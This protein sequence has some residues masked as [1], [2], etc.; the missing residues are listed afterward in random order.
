MFAPKVPKPAKDQ[1]RSHNESTVGSMLPRSISGTHSPPLS[2]ERS[3]WPS[4]NATRAQIDET[5]AVNTASTVAWNFCQVPL[6]PPL[7]LW[8]VTRLVR[9]GKFNYPQKPRHAAQASSPGHKRGLNRN[10]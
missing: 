6:Y 2:P 8:F 3:L 4:G 1:H 10:D 7:H 5:P 9:A